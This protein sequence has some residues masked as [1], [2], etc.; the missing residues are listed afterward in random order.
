MERKKAASVAVS[1]TNGDGTMKEFIVEIVNVPGQ[2]MA[3]SVTIDPE[4]FMER[5]VEPPVGEYEITENC[6]E[7]EKVE[8]EEEDGAAEGGGER[9]EAVEEV[10][11]TKEETE[12]K[13]QVTEPK[14]QETGPKEEGVQPRGKL[15]ESARVEAEGKG[16]GTNEKAVEAE[17]KEGGVGPEGKG[18]D[19]KGKGVEPKGKATEPKG[20]GAEPEGKGAEPEKEGAGK[21]AEP[22]DTGAE[23]KEKGTEPKGKGTEPKGKGAEPKDEGAEPKDEGAEPKGKGV[24]PKDKGT[25]PKAKGAEPKD[26]GAEPKGEGAE[27]KGKGAEP[28]DEGTEPKGEGPEP[29]DEGAD[30]KGQGAEPKNKGVEPNGKGVDPVEKKGVEPMEEELANKNATVEKQA[31]EKNVDGGKVM[32]EENVSGVSEER[33]LT[34]DVPDEKSKEDE[35][36]QD[37]T[38]PGKDKPKAGD[39]VKSAPD[40][41][42]SAPDDVTVKSAPATE[43]RT[44]DKQKTSSSTVAQSPAVA[45]PRQ[46]RRSR[47]PATPPPPLRYDFTM[48]EERPYV[49]HVCNKSFRWEISYSVH[50]KTHIDVPQKVRQKRPYRRVPRPA[51][52]PAAEALEGEE[53][54]KS[55]KK[56]QKKFVANS[57]IVQRRSSSES[58]GDYDEGVGV[59]C[60]VGKKGRKKKTRGDVQNGESAMVRRKI[61]TPTKRL[62]EESAAAKN[63]KPTPVANPSKHVVSPSKRVASPS[64][65]V[66]SPLKHV[67]SPPK[68]VTRTHPVKPSSSSGGKPVVKKRKAFTAIVAKTSPL[69]KSSAMSV[70]TRRNSLRTGSRRTGN[71]RGQVDGSMDDMSADDELDL[72]GGVLP[73]ILED[74]I[75]DG[76]M[77]ELIV[78]II[79]VPDAE[80]SETRASSDEATELEEVPVVVSRHLSWRRQLWRRRSLYPCRYCEKFF[81]NKAQR[82]M[83]LQRHIGRHWYACSSCS[84]RFPDHCSLS[85]HQLTH[86]ATDYRCAICAHDFADAPALAAHRRRHIVGKSVTCTICGKRYGNAVLLAKH[87][88]NHQ[89]GVF[90]CDICHKSFTKRHNFDMHQKSGCIFSAFSTDDV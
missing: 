39:D 29:K 42:K 31:A 56:R 49:C 12:P 15:G 90:P 11:I 4:N 13:E 55:P 87:E 82:A 23:P 58:D 89:T 34:N 88:V 63:R 9:V 44:G 53:A 67:P 50:L 66:P 28:K 14:E 24:E 83:H 8:G 41:V 73:T 33:A 47:T 51:A 25:E 86:R 32:A 20:K 26:K 81:T 10:A 60:A 72:S 36:K 80:I 85:V 46:K 61:R 74:G 65:H 62:I 35:Q 68:R 59:E 22:E 70:S 16:D 5:F 71:T 57:R 3:S 79:N 69:K 75:G 40:D 78:E 64:K 38:E 77:T 7:E 45:R 1:N 43:A 21:G 27:P 6:M 30:P 2:P 76:T 84:A 19:S 17:P 18:S 52:S 54:G 37:A 48:G